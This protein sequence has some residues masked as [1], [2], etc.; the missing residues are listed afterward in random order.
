MTDTAHTIE[1]LIAALTRLAASRGMGLQTRTNIV[2][3][4]EDQQ[5][6]AVYLSRDPIFGQVELNH[7]NEALETEVADLRRENRLLAK[8]RDA[9]REGILKA[10]RDLKDLT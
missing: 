4:E 1:S 2:S 8:E 3:I 7:R 10:A 5:Y 6:G 9:V